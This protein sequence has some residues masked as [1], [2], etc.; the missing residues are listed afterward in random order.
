MTHDINETMK[1]LGDITRTHIPG[2]TDQEVWTAFYRHGYTLAHIAR[3]TGLSVSTVR[4][5]RDRYDT[6]Q[7]NS[8]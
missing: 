1:A 8:K 4:R 7:E 3:E 2:A 6:N 5:M